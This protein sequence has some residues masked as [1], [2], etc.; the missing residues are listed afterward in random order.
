MS[1]RPVQLPDGV[2]GKDNYPHYAPQAKQPGAAIRHGSWKL[3]EFY[4]PPRAELC[5]LADDPGESHDL[6][7]AEPERARGL[8]D[9]L[10]NGLDRVAPI[11]HTPNTNRKPTP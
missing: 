9:K 11:R 3:I 8:F 6:A 2:F 7:A 4:D 10:H 5:D 1:G